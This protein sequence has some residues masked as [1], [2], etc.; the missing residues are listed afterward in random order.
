MVLF[1]CTF[2]HK[3]GTYSKILLKNIKI[4]IIFF[5]Y[6]YAYKYFTEEDAS[7]NKQMQ[8][9][10]YIKCGSLLFSNIKYKMITM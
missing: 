2:F 4:Y 9:L 8:K 3:T 10:L 7:F 6:L 1:T 5:L